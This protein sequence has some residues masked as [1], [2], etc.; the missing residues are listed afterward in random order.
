M[1][2][3]IKFLKFLNLE[4]HKDFIK[5]NNK[6]KSSNSQE[7]IEISEEENI[8]RTQTQSFV[9]YTDNAV[10][11]HEIITEIIPVGRN[12]ALKTIHTNTK[13]KETKL[14]REIK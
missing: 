14:E 6:E 1:F 13:I 12:K 9:E 11:E 3:L 4:Q 5:T 10:I 8:M 2:A 7:F